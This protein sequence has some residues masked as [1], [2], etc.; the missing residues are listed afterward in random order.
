M[1]DP[2]NAIYRMLASTTL[3][4][5]V[6]NSLSKAGLETGTGGYAHLATDAGDTKTNAM[7]QLVI[8]ANNKVRDLMNWFP[9]LWMKTTTLTLV[10][11]QRYVTLP[12]SLRHSDI[13]SLK[14]DS[15]TSYPGQPIAL[16]SPVE[17]DGLL[18][19]YYDGT[20][21]Y[22]YPEYACLTWETS[23]GVGL[24]NFYP[25]PASA[26][27]IT[28]QYRTAETPFDATDLSTH[29]GENV[30]PIPD[31]MCELLEIE[32]GAEI[33]GRRFGWTDSTVQALRA[34]SAQKR[35]EWVS[36][37]PGMGVGGTFDQKSNIRSFSEKLQWAPKEITY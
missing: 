31:V 21:T 7:A 33:R 15:S 12:A 36:R 25:L 26:K 35:A 2:N 20:V 24:I 34:E 10:A 27:T 13:F 30:C 4:T 3:S 5:L 37:L 9:C 6:T 22:D 19:F 23:S 14:F 16:I 18:P 8:I 11:S 17:V 1:T 28:C 32:M 29:S